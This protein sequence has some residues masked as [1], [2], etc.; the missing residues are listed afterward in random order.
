MNFNTR[1]VLDILILDEDLQM[2]LESMIEAERLIWS[3]DS[4]S[5]FVKFVIPLV[6]DELKF[7]IKNRLHRKKLG[8]LKKFINLDDVDYY[9]LVPAIAKKI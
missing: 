9:H 6:K 1:T 5:A 3:G 8:F 2:V 4:P 7:Y